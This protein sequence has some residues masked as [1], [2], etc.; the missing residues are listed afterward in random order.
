ML[1]IGTIKA[2][3]EVVVSNDYGRMTIVKV[4]KVTRSG[5]IVLADGS[6]YRDN[7]IETGSDNWRKNT[8]SPLTPELR[9]EI[10]RKALRQANMRVLRDIKWENVDDEKLAQIIAILK[11]EV[12]S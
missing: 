2:G 11:G 4:A 5:Q 3:D 9:E 8:L 12:K 1:E 6:R 7:G 10:E